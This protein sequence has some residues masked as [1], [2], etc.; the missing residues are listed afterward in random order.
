[1]SVMACPR[2]RPTPCFQYG[3][4][5]ECD[6]RGWHIGFHNLLQQGNSV[7]QLNEMMEDNVRLIVSE[8]YI[9]SYPAEYRG[10]IWPFKK[11]IGYVREHAQD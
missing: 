8:P 4:I 3:V 6:G 7:Q 1:M 11:F 2:D 9:R 10:S 5:G